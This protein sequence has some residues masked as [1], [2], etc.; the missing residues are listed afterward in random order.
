MNAC[1]VVPLTSMVYS[2][3]QVYHSIC[4]CTFEITRSYLASLFATHLLYWYNH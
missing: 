3:P 2:E 1:L 4:E